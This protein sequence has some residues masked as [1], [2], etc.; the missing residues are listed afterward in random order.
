MVGF[1]LWQKPSILIQSA[2]MNITQYFAKGEYDPT[3]LI[4]ECGTIKLRGKDLKCRKGVEFGARVYKFIP[5]AEKPIPVGL[6]KFI[7]ENGSVEPYQ[8]LPV[9]HYNKN[10]DIDTNDTI[11]IDINNAYWT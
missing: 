2:T 8:E 4:A 11:G 10:Y 6:R 5:S 1:A 7:E 9:N 3:E